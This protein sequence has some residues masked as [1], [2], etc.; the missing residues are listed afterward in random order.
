MTDQLFS[1]GAIVV[2]AAAAGVAA[3]VVDLFVL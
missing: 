2:N 3:A 1:V